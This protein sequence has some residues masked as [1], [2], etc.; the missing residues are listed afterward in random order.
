MRVPRPV[1]AVLSFVCW[2]AAVVMGMA[3]AGQFVAGGVPCELGAGRACSPRLWPLILEVTAAVLLGVAGAL[4][5]A[6]RKPRRPE[7][8]RPWE[9][10]P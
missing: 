9:Y 6:P 1:R 7:G 8:R 2:T 10:G 3:A 4:L 5:W